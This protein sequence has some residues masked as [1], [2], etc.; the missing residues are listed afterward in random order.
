MSE[1]FSK[2]SK[3][4]ES[5]MSGVSDVTPE[6]DELTDLIDAHLDLVSAA[7]GS[8]HGSGHSSGHLSGGREIEEVASS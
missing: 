7:H 2:L 1:R 5:R 3:R 6:D 8:A 4:L